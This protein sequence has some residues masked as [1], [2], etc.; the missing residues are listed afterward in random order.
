MWGHKSSEGFALA[1]ATCQGHRLMAPAVGR[2]QL[3]FTGWKSHS[4]ECRLVRLAG[5]SPLLRRARGLER[6][7][8]RRQCKPKF[9]RAQ[10]CARARN[11]SSGSDGPRPGEGSRRRSDAGCSKPDPA[12]H[13]HPVTLALPLVGGHHRSRSGEDAPSDQQ[14]SWSSDPRSLE[15]LGPRDPK[16]FAGLQKTSEIY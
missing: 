6:P 2:F 16:D 7:H 1:C 11:D 3:P 9:P 12:H 10:L 14:T 15:A 8:R 5:N 13:H 4:D